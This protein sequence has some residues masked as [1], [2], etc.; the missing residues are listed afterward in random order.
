MRGGRLRARGQPIDS[1]SIARRPSRPVPTRLNIS[2]LPVIEA[3]QQA[4]P[5]PPANR[6][7]VDPTPSL[8]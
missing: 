1:E 3:L 8:A 2:Q 7:V 6:L 5:V 4:A